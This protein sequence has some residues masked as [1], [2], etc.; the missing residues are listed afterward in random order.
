MLYLHRDFTGIREY[1]TVFYRDG[2]KECSALKG[3]IFLL[4]ADVGE[5]LKKFQK[6]ESIAVYTLF[7]E[8]LRLNYA[9]ILLPPACEIHVRYV[10]MQHNYN[11]IQLINAC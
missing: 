8:N 7:N 9:G 3:A 4:D 11:N 2:K 1:L 5:C 10:S 6:Y